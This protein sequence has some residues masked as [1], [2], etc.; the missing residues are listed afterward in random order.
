LSATL[1]LGEITYL[2]D[3]NTRQVPQP[4]GDADCF[5]TLQNY[6]E[7]RELAD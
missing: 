7:M 4:R 5:D 1:Y 2:F 3:G 6:G